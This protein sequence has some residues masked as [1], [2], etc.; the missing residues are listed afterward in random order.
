MLPLQ[1]MMEFGWKP[2]PFTVRR[3]AAP[4]GEAKFGLRLEM[5]ACPLE[6]PEPETAK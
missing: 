5:L 2:E 4:P 1:L 6:A 3:K